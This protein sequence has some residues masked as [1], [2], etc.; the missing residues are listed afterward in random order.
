MAYILNYYHIVFRTSRSHRTIEEAYERDLYMYIF[1]FCKNNRV[2]LWRINSMPD[3][4]HMLVS[5]PPDLALATFVR[6]VKKTASNYLKLHKKEFPMFEGWA[7][8]YCALTY[9]QAEKD[10]VIK[11]ISGQKE[12][13]HHKKLADEM[14]EIFDSCGLQYDE[15]YFKKDWID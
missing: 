8:G 7:D 15:K 4:I 5:L 9:S 12:H 1:A 2:K 13:H 10:N 6:E 14:Q 11:Y 3:H